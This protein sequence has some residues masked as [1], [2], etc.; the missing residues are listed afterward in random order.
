MSTQAVATHRAS[1]P[2][3]RTHYLHVYRIRPHCW[4]WDCPCGG[5]IHDTTHALPDQ[6]S[7]L[8]AA[9]VHHIHQAGA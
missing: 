1:R 7:A 2:R 5:G 9:L 3:S 4:S 8:V 6:H